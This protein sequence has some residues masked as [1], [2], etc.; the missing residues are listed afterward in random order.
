LEI[1]CDDDSLISCCA[2]LCYV[3][4]CC[5]LLCYICCAILHTYIHT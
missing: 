4:L 1:Y 2:M 3:L 5:A